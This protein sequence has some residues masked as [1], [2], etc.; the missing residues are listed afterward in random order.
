[1]KVNRLYDDTDC[2]MMVCGVI[3]GLG[4]KPGVSRYVYLYIYI[5]RTR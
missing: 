4:F 1:M 5:H 2:V 3:E